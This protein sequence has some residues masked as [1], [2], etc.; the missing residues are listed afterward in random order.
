M[1]PIEYR[2]R[3]IEMRSLNLICREKSDSDLSLFLSFTLIPPVHTKLNFPQFPGCYPPLCVTLIGWT[4][5][6]VVVAC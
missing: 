6:I 3:E 2:N 1:W 4:N 5:L